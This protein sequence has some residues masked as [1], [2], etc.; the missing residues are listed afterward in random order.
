MADEISEIIRAAYSSGDLLPGLPTAD[1]ALA[2]SA[3]LLHDL[4][5]G[6][7]LWVATLAGRTVGTVRAVRSSPDSWEVRRLAVSPAARRSGAAR[8]LLRRLEHDASAAGAARVVLDAVVERGNPAFYAQVGYR[9]VR[10]FPAG[11]K[12]LSE[13]RM[14]RDLHDDP[15]PR[16]H[17]VPPAGP[18]LLLDWLAVPAGT[19]CRPRLTGPRPGPQDEAGAAPGTPLGADFWA[20]AGPAELARVRATLAREADQAGQEELLF[21]RPAGDIAAFRA[22]RLSH[23]ELLAWWR[24]PAVRKQP[25]QRV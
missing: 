12:P 11:D 8:A 19:V 4:A 9:L 1:G 23:P 22:P 2:D 13:V 17:D 21:D 20:G 18:G 14:Q 7:L 6:Q 24:S 5:A 16:A 15:A 3:E 25:A 10:H